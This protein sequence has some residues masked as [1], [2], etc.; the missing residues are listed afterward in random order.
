[1]L[2]KERII[3]EARRLGFVD[4]GFTTADPFESHLEYLEKNREAY[5]WA[6]RLGLDIFRGSD[7]RAVMPEAK[8]IIVLIEAY[9]RESLPPSLEAHFGRCY[10]DDDRVTRDGLAVRMKAFRDFLKEHGIASKAPFDIPHR[11]A[12]ARA[13]A[14]TF[15]KNCLLYSG[16]AV[17]GSSWIFPLAFLVDRDFA[18]DEPTIGVDCPSWCRNACV[19]SCPTR[20]LKGDGTIDPRRCVSYLTYYGEGITPIELRGPMGLYVYGCDRCQNVC[21]RN[22]AW[23]AQDMPPNPRVA[24]K[25]ADFDLSALLRMDREYFERRVWPHMFYMSADDIWR[26]KMNVA[27]AMGNTG[28][29]RFVPDLVGAFGDTDDPRVRGMIAWALG[30]IGGREARAALERMCPADDGPVRDEFAMA[31]EAAR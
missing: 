23:T 25:A 7:P 1:M 14:G 15:G 26:W 24:A 17:R 2:S 19:A 20:A 22:A 31:L 13:G 29:E 6:P 5:E 27:R 12:A 30:N 9:Y 3:E 16:R 28:D 21:P 18:P 4:I 8:S 11:M 10:L